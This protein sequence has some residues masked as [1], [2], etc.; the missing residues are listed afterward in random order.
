MTIRRL[1]LWMVLAP[2][3]LTSAIPAQLPER[4]LGPAVAQLAEP[5]SDIGAVRE[6]SDGRVIV[7]DTREQRIVVANLGTGRVTPIGAKG[8]GPGEFLRALRFLALPHDTTWVVDGQGG[9]VLVIGPGATP[10]GVVTTLGPPASDSGFA[11]P[12]LRAADDLG[13]LYLVSPLVRTTRETLTPSD[14]VKISQFDRA[15]GLLLMRAVVALPESKITVHRSGK[16]VTSVEVM[17]KP[18]SVGD[19]WEVGPGGQLVI[20]RRNPYRV[21][22]TAP[23]RPLVRGPSIAV[24]AREVT[25][26]D[27]TGYLSALPNGA[28]IK[29]EAVPWPEAMPPF[30]PRAV[31]VTDREVWVRR[32]APVGSRSVSHDVFDFQG[33][34]VAAI[35]LPTS[36]RVLLVTA[37]GVY[38]ARTDDDGLQYVERYATSR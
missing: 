36:L 20:V 37:R 9:R 38:V 28:S 15:R 24:T 14:S 35:A 31:V 8:R 6:L 19:E 21:E 12:A 13:R 4:K 10:I 7:L 32:T 23:G 11:P 16:E 30:L 34:R 26:A 33:H 2:P 3:C 29:R 22:V 18:F 1:M 17:R 27:K 5:F 25:D